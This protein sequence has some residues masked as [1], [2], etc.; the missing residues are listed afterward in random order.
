MNVN[1]DM[2]AQWIVGHELLHSIS[3][4]HPD[5]YLNVLGELRKHAHNQEDFFDDQEEAPWHRFFRVD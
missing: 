1:A 4:E 3:E 2:P 5:L